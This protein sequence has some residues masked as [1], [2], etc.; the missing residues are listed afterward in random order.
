[1]VVYG[2]ISIGVVVLEL[3]S[4]SNSLVLSSFADSDSNSES[5]EEVGLW[6]G[7]RRSTIARGGC[8]EAT[9]SDGLRR[10]AIA[11]DGCLEATPLVTSK[12]FGLLVN[13]A[14]MLDASRLNHDSLLCN[15]WAESTSGRLN[16][17]CSMVFAVIIPQEKESSWI[18]CAS[19]FRLF[20][21]HWPKSSFTHS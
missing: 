16:M 2:S 9:K 20:L 8:W 11:R 15:T 12:G 1:M 3:T 21:K 5:S 13:D 7:L 18:A 19:E 6:D 14:I 10:L 17:Q 4:S